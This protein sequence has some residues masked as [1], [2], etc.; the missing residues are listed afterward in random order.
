MF[1]YW[2][3]KCNVAYTSTELAGGFIISLQHPKLAK[4]SIRRYEFGRGRKTSCAIFYICGFSAVGLF[5][6]ADDC[7]GR[8]PNLNWVRAYSHR[9]EADV[10]PWVLRSK[11]LNLF[12]LASCAR[13]CKTASSTIAGCGTCHALGGSVSARLFFSPPFFS[14]DLPGDHLATLMRIGLLPVR[15][16]SNTRRVCNAFT[17]STYRPRPHL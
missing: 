14:S 17:D 2:T 6:I 9:L 11:P 7:A 5:A 13:P 10:R 4:F 1:Y 3:Q 15:A 8:T 16:A 12:K